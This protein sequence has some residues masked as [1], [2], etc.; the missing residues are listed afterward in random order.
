MDIFK[1]FLR[2]FNFGNE[3]Y[4]LINMNIL[5]EEVNRLRKGFKGIENFNWRT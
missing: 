5:A 4:A 2:I 3:D 1:V